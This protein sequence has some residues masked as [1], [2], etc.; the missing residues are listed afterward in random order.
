MSVYE[1]LTLGLSA[2]SMLIALW[3]AFVSHRTAYH[4]RDLAS[5]AHLLEERNVLAAHHLK[6]RELLRGVRGELD[7][8]KLR[9]SESAQQAF[10]DLA[11]LFDEFGMRR[12]RRPARHVF[13]DMCE[14]VFGI[15]RRDLTKQ[16]GST[17][18]RRFGAVRRMDDALAFASKNVKIRRPASSML[19]GRALGVLRDR[20]PAI[21]RNRLLQA[22]LPVV[23]KHTEAHGAEVPLMEAA[24]AKVRL[25]MQE[26]ESEAFRLAEST[27]LHLQFQRT[28]QELDALI[29]LRLSTVK[30]LSGVKVA[31]PLSE[32]L[33]IG[34]VLYAIE[35]CMDWS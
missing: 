3:A 33:H 11:H 17:L 32:L 34:V 25:A 2:L 29:Q 15:Y 31:T 8:I 9:L 35:M 6:Y 27:D 1:M 26:G 5:R 14:M 28:A 7:D 12:E 4:Q 13:R 23:L 18:V 20:V 21:Q 24:L 30:H 16:S 22:S 19:M 10:F